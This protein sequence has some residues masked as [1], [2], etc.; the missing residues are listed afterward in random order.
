MK[1]IVMIGAGGMAREVRWLI[2][3]IN[4]REPKWHFLGYVISDLRA[5]MQRDSRDELLGDFSWL[6]QT[7]K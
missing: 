1:R 7:Y 2:S 5:V 6:T 4:L 3:E